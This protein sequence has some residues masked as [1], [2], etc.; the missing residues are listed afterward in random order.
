MTRNQQAQCVFC[1]RQAP[2]ENVVFE[3]EHWLVRHSAETNILGYFVIEAKRH[4]VDL[5]QGTDREAR[6][7][8]EILR[9]LQKAI[10]EVTHCQRVYTFSLGEAVEHF[11]LHVIPRTETVP[12]SFRG[13]GILAYPTQPGPDHALAAQTSERVARRIERLLATAGHS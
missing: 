8:G 7:Y 13:R 3:D 11:H 2:A 10:R 1:S 9:A 5:S 6:S 4:F 12:R